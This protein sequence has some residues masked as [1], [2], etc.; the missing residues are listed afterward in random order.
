M[1]PYIA[2]FKKPGMK[3]LIAIKDYFIALKINMGKTPYFGAKKAELMLKPPFMPCKHANT[4]RK[5]SHHIAFG[6]NDRA[7]QFGAKQQITPYAKIKHLTLVQQLLPT[8][9][10]PTPN[11]PTF[12][13][14][15]NFFSTYTIKKHTKN[16]KKPLA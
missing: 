14:L 15:V 8:H 11:T 4:A 5:Y 10:N 9:I 2:T 3:T 13:P 6:K 16:T 1:I 12:L 7:H